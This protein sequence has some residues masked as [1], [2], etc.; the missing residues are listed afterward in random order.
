MR[1]QS[2]SH[3]RVIIKEEVEQ[4]A[5]WTASYIRERINS[6]EPT[7]DK[8]FVLGLPTGSTPIQTYKKLVQFYKDGS[9][10]FAN[11][12]TF[13]MDEYVGIA[14]DH[15][16]SYHSF[17][18]KH[19]FDHIDIKKE[20]INI[21]DGNAEDLIFE[22][23][24]YETKIQSYGGI[25]LFLCG[26]GPNAHLGFSEAGSSLTSLTRLKT[27][28]YDTIVANSR[29]FDGDINKVPK[30][31]LTVGVQTVM[32]AREVLCIITG[33]HK[34]NALSK[35][36]EGGVNHMYVCSILQMHHKS[37][38]VCDDAATME[39]RVKTVKY[40]KGLQEYEQISDKSK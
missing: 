16:E 3:M 12:V 25:E 1:S 27:L 7:E 26:C 14:E 11:V 6:F 40:F 15:P 4:V 17:M 5:Q 9:L 22:C 2:I 31:A 8:P 39:L 19:L 36:L 28:A 33:F 29:F 35:A 18:K 10:S 23:S 24:N 38:I 32:N 13:N 30:M 21:P 34:A 37:C 20:N